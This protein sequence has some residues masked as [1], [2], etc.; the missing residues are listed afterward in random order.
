MKWAVLIS[1]WDG[2]LEKWHV[3][4]LSVHEEENVALSALYMQAAHQL[5]RTQCDIEKKNSDYDY[6]YKVRF[7]LCPAHF[8][9]YTDHGDSGGAFHAH[10]PDMRTVIELNFFKE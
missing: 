10:L 8:E 4:T 3:E 6:P 1:E 2:G 9:H 7:S 5:A